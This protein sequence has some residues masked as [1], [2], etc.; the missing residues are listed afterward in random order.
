V[1]LVQE[2]NDLRIEPIVALLNRLQ[3]TPQ[4]V[5]GHSKHTGE[6]RV[7]KDGFG[8]SSRT[9]DCKHYQTHTEQA[10]QQSVKALGI[11]A[12]Q[13]STIAAKAEQKLACREQTIRRLESDVAKLTR[14]RDSLLRRS[15][16]SGAKRR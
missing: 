13:A 1:L 14:S 6:C 5:C 3:E 16:K 4:C 2:F 7:S 8:M 15:R 9:C 12:D 11:K 10:Y